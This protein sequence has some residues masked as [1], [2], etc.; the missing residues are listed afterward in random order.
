MSVE[1]L[2]SWLELHLALKRW[3]G[4]YPPQNPTQTQIQ[5]VF[6]NLPSGAHIINSLVA[7]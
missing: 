5:F 6:L 1:L 4:I 7:V 3:N 2:G